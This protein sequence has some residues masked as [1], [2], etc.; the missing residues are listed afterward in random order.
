MIQISPAEA[1]FLLAAARVFRGLGEYAPLPAE[2]PEGLLTRL[3]E[4][5]SHDEDA[6]ATFLADETLKSLAQLVQGYDGLPGWF[7]PPQALD[8]MPVIR[9]ALASQKMLSISYWLPACAQAVER[10]VTPYFLEMRADYAYL[11]GYCHLREDERVFRVDRI[12]QVEII[13]EPDDGGDS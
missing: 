11:V 10:R 2:A 13:D 1:G 9:E 4:S 6:A 5:L 7:S 12:L 8:P 3:A